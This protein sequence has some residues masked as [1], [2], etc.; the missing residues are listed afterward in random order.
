MCIRDR[1]GAFTFGSIQLAQAQD[2]PAAEQ[3][4]SSP[5]RNAD[6]L[7]LRGADAVSYTHLQ[8]ALPLADELCLTEIN[9]VAPEADAFFPEVSPA[10]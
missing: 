5:R 6:R 7:G 1:I 10:Q 4:L 3:N 9:D 8:Q 2:A